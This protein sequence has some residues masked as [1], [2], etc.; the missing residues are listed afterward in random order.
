MP[1][2]RGG[3]GTL[4]PTSLLSSSLLSL[5]LISE[6]SFVFPLPNGYEA[7]INSC[8]GSVVT[9]TLRMY[10]LPLV[11]KLVSLKTEEGVRPTWD[12][13]HGITIGSC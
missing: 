1:S 11:L 9:W 5:L 10:V 2:S 7:T 8:K 12:A 6:G 13:V 3:G 4:I